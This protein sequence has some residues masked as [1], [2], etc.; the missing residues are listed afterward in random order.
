MFSRIVGGE[1]GGGQL[2]NSPTV[3]IV[4]RDSLA[5][6]VERA[7]CSSAVADIKTAILRAQYAAAKSAT[8]HQLQLYCAVA[9]CISHL[10]KSQ[11]WGT[12]ALDAIG[13]RL[14]KE[15]PSLRGFSG[16]NLR[17][18]RSFYLE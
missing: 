12:G 14:Q 17:F 6:P 8:D 15:V 5:T 7:A 3:W 16:G 2:S 13:V 10:S 9:G 1:N 11:K 18:V 4:Y